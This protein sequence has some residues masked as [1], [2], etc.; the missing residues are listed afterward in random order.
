MSNPT[1]NNIPARTGR[2]M[3]EDGSTVNIGD[4]FTG[5]SGTVKP[6]NYIYV[7][8]NGNDSTA[9]GSA[10]LPYLTI[11]AAI[12]AASS[13]TT[14][15]VFPGSYTESITFKAGV[16]LTSPAEYSVY[17][18]G[19]HAWTSGAG[20]IISENIVLQNPASA[21]SGTTLAVSGSQA[22]NLI[23]INSYVNS[24]SLSGAG[25]AIN[26]TNSN[27]ASKLQINDGNIN[28]THSGATAR[29]FYSTTGAAGNINANRC[30]VK[31]DNPNNVALGIGGALSFT[32]TSDA[33]TGQIAVANTA[34]YVGS[35]VALTTTSVP[36]FTTTSSGTSVLSSVPVITTASPAFTGSG[37]L[38]Y[39]AVE[40]LSTGV[41]GS[42]TLNSG[43]GAQP[44]KMAPLGM[45]ASALLPVGAVTAGL[46]DGVL[47]YT[48]THLY[49]TIGTT[50]TQLL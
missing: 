30:T 16:N 8:K 47:E 2:L 46:L 48:G 45:R 50:R 13:G 32:H 11:G 12:T 17:I 31:I 36:V 7:G 20:T 33:V 43:Y 14:I 27:S 15:F 9:D 21:A 19:N 28:V 49:F 26:W 25:D 22:V 41:G 40:Y 37:G 35:L 23:L 38:A 18:I 34:V 6:A 1:I 24:A 4:L 39:V 42:A 44:L 10:N 5:M 3:R 29:A